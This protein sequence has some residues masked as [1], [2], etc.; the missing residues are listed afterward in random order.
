[1][2]YEGQQVELT[3]EKPASGGRM[4]A[5]HLGQIVLVRGAIPGER[6][7]AWIERAE[8]RL[9]Y[10]VTREVLEPSPDRVS[11]AA[12]P[13]CGGLL[14]AHI[15]Y[16]RQLA[17]KRDVVRDAF[18]RVGR[19]PLE[20][21]FAVAGSRTDGYRMRARLHVRGSRVG[22]YR[23][24]THQLCD[25]AETGQLLQSSVAIVQEVASHLSRL[26][27]DALTS[28]SI[29]ENVA[30]DQR[31]IHLELATGARVAPSAIEEVRASTAV[32]GISAR[33]G[34]SAPVIVAGTP[35]VRDPLATLTRKRAADGD[36]ERHAESFFQGNRYLLSEL[37]TAVLDAVPTNEAVL[38]LYAGVGL[39]S[40]ALAAAGHAADITAV[41]GDRSAGQDLKRNARPYARLRPHVANV[42]AVLAARR[43]PP[44]PTTIADPPRTGL[45]KQASEGI[46]R[47]GSSR[48]IYVS[49]DPPTLAR[50]ARKLLDAGYGIASIRAFDLFPHTPHVETVVVFER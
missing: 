23:E 2:L 47:H 41:E 7:A 14:Y 18:A 42:E 5:R 36:L 15:A 48:L 17:L 11:V 26:A 16:D 45:S 27:P 29:T 37:V 44:A 1:M 3:V 32:A 8:K 50:D 25:A 30:A 46:I 22:F 38:D 9:A 39:F 24:G 31:A 21:P 10:A 12:D 4:I 49:C 6:V 28:I 13:L 33:E 19:H 40:V 34:G 20:E 35:V 43:D